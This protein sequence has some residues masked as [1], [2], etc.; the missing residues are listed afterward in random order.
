MDK[1]NVLIFGLLCVLLIAAVYFNTDRLTG[2]APTDPKSS[3]CTPT[4][5]C[6]DSNTKAY[7]DPDKGCSVKSITDCGTG[8]ICINGACLLEPTP[9]HTECIDNSCMEVDG[10][11]T[12][13]CSSNAD[14]FTSF[15]V[16]VSAQSYKGDLGGVSG[17]DAKC[18]SL[19]N[20]FSLGGTWEAWLSDYGNASASD[21]LYHSTVPYVKLNSIQVADNWADLT[22]G[23]LD[24]PIDVSNTYPL[25]YSTNFTFFVW[26]GTNPDGTSNSTMKDC[27]GWVSSSPSIKGQSGQSSQTDTRW[28]RIMDAVCSEMKLLYCFEQPA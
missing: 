20:T 9:S 24:S 8:E 18:Q 23:T 19:A 13:E 2:N 10:E 28:T 27:S 3:Y 6:L 22:D 7:G 4:W 16:F 5:F 25:N 11:G 15:R 21:E 26:T 14:C 12:D 17:A 1:N